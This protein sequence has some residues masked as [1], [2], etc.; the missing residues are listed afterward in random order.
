[1][2][3][4]KIALQYRQLIGHDKKFVA[5]VRTEPWSSSPQPVIVLAGKHIEPLNS[6][7]YLHGFAIPIAHDVSTKTTNVSASGHRIQN[8]NLVPVT[9]LYQEGIVNQVPKLKEKTFLHT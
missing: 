3:R 2:A 4:L 1:M 6:V 8:S 5:H 9:S 7:K